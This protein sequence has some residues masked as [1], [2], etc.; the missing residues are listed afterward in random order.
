MIFFTFIVPPALLSHWV[1]EE[2]RRESISNTYTSLF[3]IVLK[4]IFVG[5]KEAHL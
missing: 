1:C 2:L 5:A 4:L 3:G